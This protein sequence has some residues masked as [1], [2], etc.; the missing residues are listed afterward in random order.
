MKSQVLVTALYVL[1]APTFCAQSWVIFLTSVHPSHGRLIFHLHQSSRLLACRLQSMLFSGSLSG[2]PAQDQLN[3]SPSRTP[4]LS[5]QTILGIPPML[6]SHFVLHLFQILY[7][8]S[9]NEIFCSHAFL[10]RFNCHHLVLCCILI[11]NRIPGT[12]QA[13]INMINSV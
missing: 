10:P 12:D 3:T 8:S 5:P 11:H 13:G 9:V 2:T 6:S 1:A 4:S 7:P